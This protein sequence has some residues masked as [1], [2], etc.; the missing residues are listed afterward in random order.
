[1]EPMSVAAASYLTAR[2]QR[3]DFHIRMMNVHRNTRVDELLGDYRGL[4]ESG[5]F[6]DMVLVSGDG[7]ARRVHSLLVVATSDMVKQ[8]METTLVTDNVV[9]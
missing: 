6:T 2:Q 5:S 1:M 3:R 4:Q 7:R 8:W 9:G